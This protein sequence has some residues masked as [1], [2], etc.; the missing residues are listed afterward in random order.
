LD[1]ESL[2]SDSA[3]VALPADQELPDPRVGQ[4]LDHFR[5]VRRLGQGGMGTVY[6]ALDE[7]LQRYVALKVIRAGESGEAD[8]SQM[9][10]LV[11]EARAQARVSHPNVLH[12]YYVGRDE[13]SPFF[14]ME[15]VEEPTLAERLDDG[16]L[17]FTE[18]IDTGLQ[19]VD[20][21]EHAARFDIVHGDIKPSNVLQADRHTIKLS[22]FG[23]ARRLSQQPDG[24]GGLIGT[25]NYLSPEAARG[26]P[27]DVRS[28]MYSLGVTLFEM[29]FGRLPY[30]VT[31]GS[32][33]EKLKAHEEA[34]IEFPEPWPAAV[35]E[36]YRRVLGRLLA[37]RPSDRYTDYE[38]LR[39]DLIRVRP[40]ALP[41]AGRVPRA[42]AW[43]FDL[44]LA[45]GV[46][47]L[48]LAPFIA[49]GGLA[50]LER[51]PGIRLPYALAGTVVPLLA[52]L[53][54]ARWGTTPGK[55][56]FQ[57]RIVD[58]HGLRPSRTKLALRSVVQ[59]FPLWAGPLSN[60]YAAFG[61]QV[62]AA[63]LLLGAFTA[64][65]ID[66]AMAALAPGGR[67]LHDI[68]FDTRVVLEARGSS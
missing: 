67:S 8:S 11:Q 47:A 41:P 53:L 27:I 23:L 3:T 1:V 25:P 68:V 19:L 17:P 56:L 65:A 29:T 34:P 58:G 13:R 46:G 32:L 12:I 43:I 16:P 6:K 22:D 42:L 9:Q 4:Q 44:V 24:A 63:V 31:S 26:E 61:L 36:A 18:V 14:A 66:A 51:Y 60:V 21:L 62:I 39:Q 57:I 59:F 48:P 30:S 7:S 45:T 5:I 35:P 49:A 40:V 37:K 10:S 28:D 64:L 20:A 50:L 52:M 2:S 54:Q 15:L 38:E 55:R 33:A